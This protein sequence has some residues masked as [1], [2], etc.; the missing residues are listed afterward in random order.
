MELKA[1]F[2]V[3]N[4]LD[5]S[6]AKVKHNNKNYNLRPTWLIWLQSR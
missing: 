3:S 6:T 4:N 5:K 1:Y 2:T